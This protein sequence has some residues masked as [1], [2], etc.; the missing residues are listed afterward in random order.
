MNSITPNTALQRTRAAVSLQ[1][2]PGKFST[3]GH[4]RAPLSFQAFGVLGNTRKVSKRGPQ[5]LTGFCLC[6]LAVA[7]MSSSKATVH[8]DGAEQVLELRHT[9]AGLMLGPCATPYVGHEGFTYWIRLSGPGPAFTA[10]DLEFVDSGGSVR[11]KDEG[12][13]G[14]IRFDE[15]GHNVVVALWAAGGQPYVF[16][17]TYR[18][19]VQP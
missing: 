15:A 2:L 17:G 12:L 8:R 18:V 5:T 3:F 10:S 14:E 16:N 7:C 19:K 4:R 9:M 1:S 11:P 13:R 6:I